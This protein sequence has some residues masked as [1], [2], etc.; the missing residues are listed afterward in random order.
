M[1][2]LGGYAALPADADGFIDAFQ[3]LIGFRAH[4]RDVHAAVGLHRFGRFD[5][6]A[7]G[8]KVGGRINERGGN[9]EGT[10]FHRPAHDFAHAVQLGR[11]G[12]TLG[13]PFGVSAHVV[14]TQ[15]GTE[16]HRCAVLLHGAQ[17]VVEAVFSGKRVYVQ[18]SL[19][20]ASRAQHPAIL[21]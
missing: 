19:R 9:A 18:S 1:E 3:E 2:D 14:A 21:R 12:R 16:V 5:Q 11:C 15:E 20:A 7:R 17:P 10:T 8:G 13:I 4:V 6:L